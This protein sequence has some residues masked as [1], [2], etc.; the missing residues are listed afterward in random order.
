MYEPQQQPV[1]DPLVSEEVAEERGEAGS[2]FC[3]EMSGCCWW[4][5]GAGG[6]GAS[7]GGPWE[8]GEDVLGA[9]TDA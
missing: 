3:G 5:S 7:G 1:Q 4:C 6:S 8:E 9:G 2:F